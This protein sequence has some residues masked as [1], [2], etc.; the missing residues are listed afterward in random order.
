MRRR[1][2]SIPSL[3]D[4][5]HAFQTA[6]QQPARRLAAYTVLATFLGVFLILGFGSG[7]TK[8]W[9]SLDLGRL[10]GFPNFEHI[11]G[12]GIRTLTADDIKSA[13]PKRFVV[14]GDIHGMHGSFKKLLST[15]KYSEHS[16]YLIHVGDLVAKGPHSD[17]VLS[18]VSHANVTGVRG[19]H[20]QKVIEWRQ[21]IE[22]VQSHHGGRAWL[23]DMESKTDSELE[24][25]KKKAG[26]RKW[27]IPDGWEFGGEHYLIARNMKAHEADYIS[28][29]P[30]V[31]HVPSYHLFFVHA[32]L[33]PLNPTIPLNSKHQPLSHVPGSLRQ[34]SDHQHRAAR[35]VGSIDNLEDRGLAG[36]DHLSRKG[37]HRD[38]KNARD[39]R[40]L[41]EEMI[42]SGIPQNTIPFNVL[43][44]RSLQRNEPVKSS[45]K[46][47]PWSE[48]WNTVVKKCDGFPDDAVR[49]ALSGEGL[50]PVKDK[51]GKERD[52][53]WWEAMVRDDGEVIDWD[54]EDD[55]AINWS[56][57]PKR[58]PCNPTTIIY[59][60]AAGRGLDI[61]RWSLGLDSGCVYGRRMSAL[62]F[63]EK[64]DELTALDELAAH[65]A[66]SG[67]SDEDG[68]PEFK[69][70][71]VKLGDVLEDGGRLH[72]RIASVRCPDV[73]A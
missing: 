49:L 37:H 33:L 1:T 50:P 58:L 27:K 28:N 59:G 44:M 66:R 13:N 32:G 8:D 70:E 57:I 69:V 4:A 43:N 24:D 46:G 64:E 7:Y 51:D 61:K 11:P 67:A 65:H 52:M 26:K 53:P 72:G 62:I 73:G 25:M 9:Q 68:E 38:P 19:N 54:D 2:S 14:V 18:T 15:V 47:R 71:K 40:T 5:Q 48:V 16:D 60:H 20:D 23:R 29:L 21:W 56:R 41:Q 10:Q 30:L 35:Q 45:K 55:P 22:W 12:N 39:L 31:I 42:L 63:S 34:K 3:A 17:H 6:R 36:S